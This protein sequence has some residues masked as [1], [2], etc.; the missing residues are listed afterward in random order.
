VVQQKLL[1][2]DGGGQGRGGERNSPGRFQVQQARPASEDAEATSSP[3]L[4]EVVREETMS[5]AWKAVRANRGGPGVDGMSV[6]L[7]PGQSAASK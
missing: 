5:R 3:L 7:F 4:E 1:P 2:F 6:E